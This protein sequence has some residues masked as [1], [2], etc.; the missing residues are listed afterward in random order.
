MDR[1]GKRALE[2]LG[3]KLLEGFGDDGSIAAVL[4]VGLATSAGAGVVNLSMLDEVGVDK[5]MLCTLLGR[6]S[7]RPWGALFWTASGTL[8]SPVAWETPCPLSFCMLMVWEVGWFGLKCSVDVM[9]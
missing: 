6:L 5:L 9:K 7:S 1:V 8:E 2:L 3:H 4:G